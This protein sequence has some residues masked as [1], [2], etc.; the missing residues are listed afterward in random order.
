MSNPPSR[1]CTAFSGDRL[2]HS[3]PLAEV[4]IAIRRS[5]ETDETILVFDDATGRVVDLDLR[6][7][8][9][10][11]VE[12]LSHPPK[13]AAGSDRPKTGATS[14]LAA[15]EEGQEQKSRG[16]PKL[17]V[18][19]REVTLLPRQWE[20]LTTQPGGASAALRR[21]VDGARKAAHP[22]QEK[23]AAQEAAYR[24]MQVI[25]GNLPGYE[26]AIRALFADDRPVLEERTIS[27]PS[28]I[29][30]YAL[31]LAFRPDNHQHS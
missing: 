2:L 29:R 12:R 3:G 24:F 26:E 11:I 30:A 13:A 20:W 5:G 10:D 16:R 4:A 15:L 6:G 8:D 19:A 22:H 23:Q 27:W 28:D 25:A 17:G 21:L 9:T 1:P 31:R 14:G 7:A 18:V